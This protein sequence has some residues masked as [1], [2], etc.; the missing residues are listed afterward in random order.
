MPPSNQYQD[1]LYTV[2]GGKLIPVATIQVGL[3]GALIINGSSSGG[4]GSGGTSPSALLTSVAQVKA[5]PTVG[6]ALPQQISAYIG[7]VLETFILDSGPG[8][9]QPNDYNASTNN[10]SWTQKQ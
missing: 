10:V 4:G 1:I 8:D 3:D 5:V 6:L 9:F 7:G 2:S